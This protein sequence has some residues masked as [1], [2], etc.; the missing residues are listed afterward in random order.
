MKAAQKQKHSCTSGTRKLK[1]QPTETGS[2]P[3]LLPPNW[4]AL[5][6]RERAMCYDLESKKRRGKHK[7]NYKK[8][9]ETVNTKFCKS[10][11]K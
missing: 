6:G 5:E 2:F 8:P 1:T 9:V 4:F 11:C 10:K 3:L 7:R